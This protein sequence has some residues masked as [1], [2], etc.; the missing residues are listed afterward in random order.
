MEKEM[1][2]VNVRGRKQQHIS[3]SHCQEGR[4]VLEG[5]DTTHG[6]VPPSEICLCP[7]HRP[8]QPATS[9]PCQ[10]A[11]PFRAHKNKLKDM[12]FMP[13][14]LGEDRNFTF[15]SVGGSQLQIRFR[16]INADRVITD[17]CSPQTLYQVCK[18]SG[19]RL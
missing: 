8:P 1:G 15:V 6:P 12:T 13:K 17:T 4:H 9:F 2:R 10:L 16:K 3:C 18:T 19:Q 14:H 11:L 5:C 7:S